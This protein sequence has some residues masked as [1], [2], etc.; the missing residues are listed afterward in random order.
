[1]RDTRVLYHLKPTEKG[2]QHTLW[3]TG[4]QNGKMST[5]HNL[6]YTKDCEVSTLGVLPFFVNQNRFPG[7]E[8][9]TISGNLV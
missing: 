5:R 8:N 7:L 4:N 3:E 6:C 1:M 9:E 2:S